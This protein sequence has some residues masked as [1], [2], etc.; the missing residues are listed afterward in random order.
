MKLSTNMIIMIVF[1]MIFII[2]LNLG[3]IAAIVRKPPSTPRQK[4]SKIDLQSLQN[5][6]KDEDKQWEELS[7]Q[8]ENLQN[9]TRTDDPKSPES[10]PHQPSQ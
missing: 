4:V 5:P 10:P 3:L 2:I 6:W 8:V 1:L 7:K 9:S